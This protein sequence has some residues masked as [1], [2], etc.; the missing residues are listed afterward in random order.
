MNYLLLIA[1]VSCTSLKHPEPPPTP[2]K[3]DPVEY[4]FPH[5]PGKCDS[6]PDEEP[7]R[8]KPET[9]PT[10]VATV[11]GITPEDPVFFVSLDIPKPEI[12]KPVLISSKIEK[13]SKTAITS[14][15]VAGVDHTEDGYTWVGQLVLWFTFL[16]IGYLIIRTI[17]CV[18]SKRTQAQSD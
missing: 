13:P 3:V 8:T 6:I 2:I 18:K 7:V 9:S 15:V 5:I 17:T 12:K 16:W 1:L 14:P 11:T 10:T 4:Q